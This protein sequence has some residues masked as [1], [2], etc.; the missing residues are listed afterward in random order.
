MWR[1]INEPH[2]N[3]IDG[4]VDDDINGDDDDDTFQQ[5]EQLVNTCLE[6]ESQAVEMEALLK[7]K[8]ELKEVERS[9]TNE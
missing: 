7:Q 4:D 9:A 6:L 3:Y 2:L 5:N 1:Y 8:E